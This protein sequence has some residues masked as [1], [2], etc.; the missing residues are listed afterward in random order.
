MASGRKM[1]LAERQL[2]GW[3]STPRANDSSETGAVVAGYSLERRHCVG[4]NS[5]LGGSREAREGGYM[6]KGEGCLCVC[7]LCC[8]TN[9]QLAR[10]TPKRVTTCHA[11]FDVGQVPNTITPTLSSQPLLLAL[12]PVHVF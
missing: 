8:L 2:A 3:V 7:D 1:F 10:P 11:Y 6:V 5:M 9:I 12:L 4:E